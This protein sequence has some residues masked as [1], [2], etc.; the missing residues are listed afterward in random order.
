MKRKKCS[1]LNLHLFQKKDEEEKEEEEEEDEEEQ[2]EE[3]QD[4]EKM[5]V[6]V[7][8]CREQ[9]KIPDCESPTSLLL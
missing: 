6:G 7:D 1:D 3:E 5:F 9:D 2:D 4:E 8:G